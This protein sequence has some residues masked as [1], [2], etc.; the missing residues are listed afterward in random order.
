MSELISKTFNIYCD[1][2]CHIEHDHKSFMFLGSV[3]S[4][5]NQVR[6]HTKN[7]KD[8]KAKHHFYGE[9]KWTSVSKSKLHFY[10]E[11]VE[12]FFA[13][14]LQ[15]RAIGIEKSQIKSA[16]F[17]NSYDEFY[18]KM[19]YYLLNHN[20][21]GKQI[22]PTPKDGKIVMDTLFTHLTTVIVDK[23][24]HARSFEMERSSRLHWVK[25][26]IDDSKTP[27]MLHFT[28]KEPEGMRTYIYDI[29]EKYVI[30]LEPKSE[31]HYYLLTAYYIQGKDAKRDK[32]LK[33]YNRREQFLL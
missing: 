27:N 14:D 1:E 21:K 7:I 22:T 17:N 24:T 30:V 31:S 18:Y 19:Y 8:L 3:S 28:V 9:I 23:L 11:L 20:I 4:A 16:E 33:K 2:S 5:Y 13:T 32:I 29:D 25:F 6:F 15:F 12:Y 26:H 10:L